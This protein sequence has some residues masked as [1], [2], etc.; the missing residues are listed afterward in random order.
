[1]IVV[2]LVIVFACDYCCAFCRGFE[3]G[4][5][6]VDRKLKNNESNYE[7]IMNKHASFSKPSCKTAQGF[8][9]LT[10]EHMKIIIRKHGK[11]RTFE[12]LK[13]ECIRHKVKPLKRT[14]FEKE[15]AQI[16][17][18]VKGKLNIYN[19]NRRN[20]PRDLR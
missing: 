11:Q 16:H 10:I 6:K 8:G 9:H 20:L 2:V 3:R 13:K 18:F 12:I 7:G 19:R 14:E 15:Y 4:F 5:D 1:M 17:K